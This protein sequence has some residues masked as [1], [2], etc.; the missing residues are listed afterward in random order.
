M[1]KL[2]SS[3]EVLFATPLHFADMNIGN[4]NKDLLKLCNVLK[5]KESRQISN[6]GGWQSNDV[7]LL[8]PAIHN[9]TNAIYNELYKYTNL[10]IS[11]SDFKIKIVN[12]W[13]NINKKY[14]YNEEH[15]HDGGKSNCDFAGVYYLKTT[16]KED[17]GNLYF[18]N[19]DSRVATRKMFFKY[20]VKEYNPF[21]SAR[22]NAIPKTHKLILF[23]AHLTHATKPNM[24]NQDRISI[25]FNWSVE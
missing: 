6:I 16:N 5:K 12:L 17:C 7:D 24:S 25:A 19:P 1:K 13:F 14:H 11:G 2:D 8:H 20:P 9:F 21:N 18:T 22:F 4:F 15:A 10:Y 23:P 3:T